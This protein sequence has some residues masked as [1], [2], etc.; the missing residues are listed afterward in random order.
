MYKPFFLTLVS[1]AAFKKEF[2]YV[3]C[4]RELKSILIVYLTEAVEMNVSKVSIQNKHF[5]VNM[6]CFCLLLNASY[7]RLL[8]GSGCTGIIFQEQD[9]CWPPGQP[10]LV[11]KRT[12]RW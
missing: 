12:S 8:I 11:I 6:D 10:A 3:F 7:N 4:I 9:D 5:D 1:T 2:C